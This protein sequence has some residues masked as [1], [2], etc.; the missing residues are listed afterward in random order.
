MLIVYQKVPI[1][2]GEVIFENN[3]YMLD[4]EHTLHVWIYK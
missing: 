2:F 4:L 3:I 1:I